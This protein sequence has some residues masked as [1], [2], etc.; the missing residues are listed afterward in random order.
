[1]CETETG[2][3]LNVNADTAATAVAQALGAEKLV[4]LSDVNGVRR[5]KNDPDSLIH[6][7][8]AN[9][10]RRLIAER[11]DRGRH[12]PQG[13]SLP[14][15]AAEGRAQDPH[16]R[17]PNAAFADAGDLH[18]PRA[19]G[20]KSSL[21]R[22]A[23]VSRTTDVIT[24]WPLQPRTMKPETA[25]LFAKYVMPNYTRFPVSLVRG[26]GSLRVGRRGAA[27]SRLLSRLGLQP[28][29]PLSAAGG[30]GGSGAGGRADPRAQH[31]AHRSPGPLGPDAV[32]SGASAARRSSATRAPRPTRRRSSWPGCT[33]P[34]SATRSSRSAAAFTA[35]PTAPRAPRPSR[36]ITK[37]SG[38]CWPASS[39][40]RSAT[41]TPWPS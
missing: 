32:A 37:A 16:H 3:R 29:G 30:R 11:R 2:E 17:R 19:S 1:M 27:V 21:R 38:R 6:S 36:S 13:R 35:A 34:T 4:F 10:A 40:R 24:T 28:A 25:E 7:L 5:D 23:I 8:T 9:E 18:E 12:D 41:S 39:T 20:R 14:G 26:E 15:N 33:R 22:A 31:L